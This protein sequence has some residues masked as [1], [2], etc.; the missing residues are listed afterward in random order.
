M[1]Q[2]TPGPMT[3]T[4][5]KRLIVD[6]LEQETGED[7]SDLA[8]RVDLDQTCD[9]RV[10]SLSMV[11]IAIDLED[12]LGIRIEDGEITAERVRS[13][14]AFADFLLDKLAGA[15]DEGPLHLGRHGATVMGLEE[16]DQD[17][18]EVGT[19]ETY[20]SLTED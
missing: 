9:A 18:L 14:D 12:A 19:A 15:A 13:L 11:N 8:R 1:T 5:L 7:Y 6:L 2:P 16:T 3:K 17:G 20:D 10:D 4:E